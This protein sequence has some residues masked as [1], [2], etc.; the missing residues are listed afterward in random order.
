M[1]ATRL[2]AKTFVFRSL[3]KQELIGQYM[4]Q[5]NSKVNEK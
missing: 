2:Q 1:S 5:R 4:K 3:A